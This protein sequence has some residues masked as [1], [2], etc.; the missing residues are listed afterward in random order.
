MLI[1]V[2]VNGVFGGVFLGFWANLCKN[3]GGK[4]FYE[5]QCICYNLCNTSRKFF[6]DWCVCISSGKTS[7]LKW[8]DSLYLMKFCFSISQQFIRKYPNLQ[9]FIMVSI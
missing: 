3:H 1:K 5:E 8:L 9:F 6:P 2:G 4:F 7:I